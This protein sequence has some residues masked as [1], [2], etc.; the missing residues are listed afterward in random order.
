MIIVEHTQASFNKNYS[1]LQDEVFEKGV[2]EIFN[3]FDRAFV[4][5]N[6]DDVVSYSTVKILS[7]S[8]VFLEMGGAAPK[9]KNTAYVAKS[10]LYLVEHLFKTFKEITMSVRNNNFPM[11]KL[12]AK[13]GFLITGTQLS[14]DGQ[15]MLLYSLERK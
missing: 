4:I 7:N 5:L 8:V 1:T 9:Y 3:T 14:N 15:L 12:A 2:A 13:L 10:F 11:I 6:N